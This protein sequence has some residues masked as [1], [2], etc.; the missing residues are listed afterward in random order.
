MMSCVPHLLNHDHCL[1]QCPLSV[2][3]NPILIQYQR[4]NC[5]SWTLVE[6][7]NKVRVSCTTY[8]ELRITFCNKICTVTSTVSV[9]S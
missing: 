7:E 1:L 5:D 9:Q 8:V 6:A 4:F 3:L 2:E